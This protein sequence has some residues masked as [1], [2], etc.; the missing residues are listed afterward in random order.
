MMQLAQKG[1][2]EGMKISLSSWTNIYF[3]FLD[4]AKAANVSI[5]SYGI[6][7]AGEEILRFYKKRVDLAN[8]KKLIEYANNIGLY[9]VGNFIFGAP[10]ETEASILKTFD[11]IQSVPFDNVNLKILTYMVGADLYATLPRDIKR[12]NKRYVLAC[13]ENGLNQFSLEELIQKLT[14]FRDDYH[15]SIYK[16][17]Q[18]RYFYNPP[19]LL[20]NTVS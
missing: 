8:A 16:N 4:L 19:Y 9:S 6:E 11:Y 17:Q 5:I 2:S 13:K 15:R 20:T 14:Q 1:I 12:D 3:K 7:S 10:M 18:P